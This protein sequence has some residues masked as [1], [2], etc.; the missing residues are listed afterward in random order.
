MGRSNDEIEVVVCTKDNDRTVGQ[1]LRCIVNYVPVSRLVVIDGGSCDDTLAIVRAFSADVYEDNGHG[2]GYAR[3]MALEIVR[4]P[5]FAFIDADVYI[6]RNWFSLVRYFRQP[7]TVAANGVTLYGYGTP[8]LQKM[9]ERM[10]RKIAT[11]VCF[12]NTLLKKDAIKSL[13]GIRRDLPSNE[14][15]DLYERVRKNNLKWITDKNV[16]SL[17]P[18]SLTG[19][20]RHMRWWARGAAKRRSALRPF[21][22]SL[23]FSPLRAIELGVTC[24]P[25][26]LL[27]YPILRLYAL[28]GYAEGISIERPYCHTKRPTDA[29]DSLMT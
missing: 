13:G 7:S 10:Y 23:I 29:K 24:H 20:L 15:W 2:L 22:S 5:L 19:H 14:D 1:A 4:T 16:V 12:T 27:Y 28:I 25:V 21:A 6:P 11:H 9:Y 26:L 17:H 8:A 18:Q 3:N